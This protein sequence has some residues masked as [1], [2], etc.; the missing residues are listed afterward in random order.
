MSEQRKLYSKYIPGLT[1][2]KNV[3]FQIGDEV[4]YRASNGNE[5]I[6]T[7]D[8]ERMM[9][10]TGYYGYEATFE[11][12]KRGFAI[13]DGIYDWKGRRYKR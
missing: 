12:G 10:I 8:S 7:I 3:L 11:N 6:V 4:K 13:E 5:Y 2:G 1:S 9:H